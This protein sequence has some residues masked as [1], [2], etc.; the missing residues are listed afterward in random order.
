MIPFRKWC[1]A[2]ALL[3]GCMTASEP[4]APPPVEL[5]IVSAK[6]DSATGIGVI[7]FTAVNRGSDTVSLSHCGGQIDMAVDRAEGGGWTEVNSPICPANNVMGYI[8]LA[9]NEEATSLA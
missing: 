3:V 1:I 6:P 7:T 4:S 9:P 2:A 5:I 8:Q